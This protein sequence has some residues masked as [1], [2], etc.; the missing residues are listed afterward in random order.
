M[1][2]LGQR[3]ERLCG[4]LRISELELGVSFLYHPELHM[5]SLF[6]PLHFEDFLH[7]DKIEGKLDM[8]TS[9]GY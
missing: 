3:E 8:I 7:C 9:I 4:E 2:V 6:Y 1:S 5:P